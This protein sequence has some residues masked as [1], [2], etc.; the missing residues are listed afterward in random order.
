MSTP[1]LTVC[2]VNKRINQRFTHERNGRLE[3]P[4]PGTVVDKV[5][6]QK[7]ADKVQY[8]FYLIAQN[9]TQGCVT[10]THYFVAYDDSGL[11]K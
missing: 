10:P 1:K 5:L 7:D 4:P 2:V 11:P 9:A 6:V 3:N 8:D